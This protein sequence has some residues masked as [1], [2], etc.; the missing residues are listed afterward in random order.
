MS[1]IWLGA[2]NRKISFSVKPSVHFTNLLFY[3]P[4]AVGLRLTCNV[5]LKC[6]STRLFSLKKKKL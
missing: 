6:H 3:T 4:P 2:L 5:F 1:E